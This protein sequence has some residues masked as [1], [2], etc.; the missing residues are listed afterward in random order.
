MNK[1]TFFSRWQRQPDAQGT[2]DAHNWRRRSFFVIGVLVALVCA[3][4]GS[5]LTSAW[6][7][8]SSA[9]Q[10]ASSGQPNFGSNVYIFTPSMPMSDIQAT[11][12]AVA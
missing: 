12:D 2:P 11:V 9:S 1:R 5:G 4:A 6:A 3:V 8:T 10:V 7:S